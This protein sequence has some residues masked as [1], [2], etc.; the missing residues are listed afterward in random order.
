MNMTDSGKGT[1]RKMPGTAHGALDGKYLYL[2]KRVRIPRESVLDV[3]PTPDG[4]GAVVVT[5]RG[6]SRVCEDYP[7]L[8]D[9]LFGADVRTPAKG[10]AQ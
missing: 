3:R 2:T 4:W 9:C 7:V 10:G 8:M 5:D 6:A 1:M